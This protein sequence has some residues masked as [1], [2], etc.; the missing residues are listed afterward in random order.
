MHLK[1]VCLCGSTLRCLL[2]K[3]NSPWRRLKAHVC[4]FWLCLYAP[5]DQTDTEKN[6]KFIKVNDLERNRKQQHK[7]WLMCYSPDISS[8]TILPSPS[9]AQKKLLYFNHKD[10]L[11]RLKANFHC[12]FSLSLKLCIVFLFLIWAE[13]LPTNTVKKQQ[14]KYYLVTASKDQVCSILW[15]KVVW[16]WYRIKDNTKRA[17]KVYLL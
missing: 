4:M 9:L 8:V 7:S 10:F 15:L 14:S 16:C 11:S 2:E 1:E 3:G 5:S 6:P 17:G 12:P 13:L